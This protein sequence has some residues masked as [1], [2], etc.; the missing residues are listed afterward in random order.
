MKVLFIY[1]FFI[2]SN[3]FFRALE[4]WIYFF[5]P[6][7][8]LH[9]ACFYEIFRLLETNNT[10]ELYEIL[11]YPFLHYQNEFIASPIHLCSFSTGIWFDEDKSVN[12]CACS[13]RQP[14]WK[15]HRPTRATDEARPVLGKPSWVQ[16]LSAFGP[17]YGKVRRDIRQPR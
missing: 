4:A 12:W 1:I 17:S 13:G 16:N 2:F 14:P 9:A 5:V 11:F 8:I 3:N 15:L 7:A 10:I 6:I